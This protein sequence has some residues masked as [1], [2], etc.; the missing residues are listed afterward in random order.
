[1]KAHYPNLG[2]ARICALFGVTRQAYYQ[3]QWSFM[4]QNT[5]ETLLL[6]L[7]KEIRYKHPRLGGRKLYELLQQSLSEH[8]I[9]MGRDSLFD[10]LSRYGL[11]V[12]KR[13]R[14][15]YTTQ[16]FHHYKKHSN[17]IKNKPMPIKANEIW[18]SDITYLKTANGFV[19]VSFITDAYSRKIVGY[20]VAD[21][22]EAVHSIEALKMALSNFTEPL[23]NLIHHSDRGVQYC[24]DAYVKMLE[25]H[26][27]QISMTE[28]GDPLDNAIAER[29][30]GILKEEYL[31]NKQ[32]LNLIDAKKELTESVKMYNTE[33][34]H[35][36]INM[37]TPNEAHQKTGEIK[38]VWK[39]GYVKT[40]M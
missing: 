13:K 9:K 7:I 6:I 15:I 31:L 30:N 17:L 33:R 34:P 10:L 8:H 40:Y 14:R 26:Q 18:V 20:Y 32:L 24:C 37:L 28:S 4:E 25:D 5:E 11:L 23:T 1:M 3:Y 39:N 22:L 35:M 38:R 27:I 29:V 36:S 16:S 2:L 19:Y 21:T 12:R